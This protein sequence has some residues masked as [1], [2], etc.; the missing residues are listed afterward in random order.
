MTYTAGTSDSKD[1][2]CYPANKHGKHK[3]SFLL[4]SNLSVS[5][6][7][8]DS[9]QNNSRWF[10][11][12]QF[13]KPCVFEKYKCKIYYKINI[14]AK[15]SVHYNYSSLSWAK[16]IHNILEKLIHNIIQGGRKNSQNSHLA[17]RQ[18]AHEVLLLLET[19]TL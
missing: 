12:W 17:T 19:Q 8:N 18:F 16:L 6:S 5:R 4:E 13:Y 14:I 1:G 9:N 11:P 15:A 3:L 7:S 10:I 2:Y